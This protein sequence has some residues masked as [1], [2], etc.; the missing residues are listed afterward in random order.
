MSDFKKVERK[1]RR[2]EASNGKVDDLELRNYLIKKLKVNAEEQPL[3]KKEEEEDLIQITNNG[4]KSI[5]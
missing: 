3:L 4:G 2:N 1:K 5:K